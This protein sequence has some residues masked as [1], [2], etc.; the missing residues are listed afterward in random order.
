MC[1]IFGLAGSPIKNSGAADLVLDLLEMRG[2]D[3]KGVV[4][5][6]SATLG[7]TR[8]AIQDAENGIQPMQSDS[9]VSTL[10]FNGEIY[11]HFELRNMLP[12]Q[13]WNTQSDTETVVELIEALGTEVIS[14]FIGM[15]AFGIW[16]NEK[17]ELTL[18]RDP[19]GEKPLYYSVDKNELAFCSDPRGISTLLNRSSALSIDEMPYFLKYGYIRA[20]TSSFSNVKMLK[21]GQ[22]LKWTNSGLHISCLQSQKAQNKNSKFE[23]TELRT[24]L[25]AAVERTLL[26]DGSVGVM[27]SGGLDSSIIAA[28]ASKSLSQI[29]TYTVSLIENSEDARFARELAKQLKTNHYEIKINENGLAECIEDILVSAPQPFADSAIISTYILSKFASQH[30]KVLLTG[31]G[32][33]E[34]FAGYS[35]YEKYK[36]FGVR[37]TPKYESFLKQI[38]YEISKDSRSK[39]INKNREEF[40]ESLLT[41]GRISP[42]TSWSQDLAA[43]TDTELNRIFMSGC[44][45]IIKGDL[46]RGQKNSV[47]WDVLYADQKSYLA[48]DILRKSDMGGMLASIEIRSPY[49]DKDLTQYLS[50]TITE[51]KELNKKIL[52]NS[53]KDLIPGEILRRRKQGFGAPLD[54]WLTYPS[55]DKLMSG[56]LNNPK[57][58][59]YQYFEYEKVLSTLMKSHLKKWNFFALAIW[60]ENN[61]S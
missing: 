32:A 11:N 33:D 47:F 44:N 1:G 3:D 60:F 38:R 40:R 39:R 52:Y 55:I 25:E 43:F 19:F 41:S 45:Q 35:Y 17:S 59:I 31:D 27:L 5:I 28:L 30:V 16:N 42:Q 48:G 22:I 8:L 36:E 4:E 51:P 58:K 6:G 57:S 46:G 20:E 23:I 21:P 50:E 34:I 24:K 7:H 9:G 61:G 37:K 53:C 56:V 18:G 26:A 10:V 29:P 2:P 13:K 49:L 14:K 15:F 54:I 12:N